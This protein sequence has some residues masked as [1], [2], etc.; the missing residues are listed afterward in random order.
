[1]NGLEQKP[2]R[3]GEFALE[4]SFQFQLISL[5][6]MLRFHAHTFVNMTNFLS[7]IEREI[8][9][10]A[11]V[12]FTADDDGV[13]DLLNHIESS[14][15]ALH[16]NVSASL[17]NRLSIET[18][19]IGNNQQKFAARLEGISHTIESELQQHHFFQVRGELANKYFDVVA[20]FGSQI[21]VSF[22]A[23]TYDIDEAAKC[24]VLDRHTASVFHLFR[25][26]E[27]GLRALAKD[28]GVAY[29]VNGWDALLKKI[30]TEQNKKRDEKDAV[31]KQKESFYTD[32]AAHLRNYKLSR[33]NTNH[34]DKKYSQAEADL[35][36]DSVRIF[37]QHLATQ[38]SEKP[39]TLEMCESESIKML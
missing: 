39:E 29:T 13:R 14:C 22:P 20:W 31:F 18:P 19:R 15:R 8:S 26:V 27:I 30:D 32:A 2:V 17:V 6:D 3:A 9:S 12:D 1:M 33:N 10:Q 25:V 16:L 4:L 35:I 24:F 36:F 7:R 5:F 21:F 38:I 11:E 28:L 23:A 37:M 34:P